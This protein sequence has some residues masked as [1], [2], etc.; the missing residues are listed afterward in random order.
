MASALRETR[1][2]SH[3][4]EG[5][6]GRESFSLGLRDGRMELGVK[7]EREEDKESLKLSFPSL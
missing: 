6:R 7:V 4:V 1:A 5:K 3:E 2:Y